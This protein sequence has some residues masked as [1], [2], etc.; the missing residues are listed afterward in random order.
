MP[1]SMVNDVRGRIDH[2]AFLKSKKVSEVWKETEAL[3]VKNTLYSV[4]ISL[5]NTFGQVSAYRREKLCLND[6]FIDIK[7]RFNCQLHLLV[8]KRTCLENVSMQ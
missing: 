3:R 2:K 6:W 1:D 7:G 5:M 4:C 8:R